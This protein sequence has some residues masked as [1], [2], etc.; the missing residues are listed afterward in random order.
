VQHLFLCAQKTLFEAAAVTD[1]Q[2]AARAAQ[3]LQ[4][5]VSVG[6]GKC[7][8]FLHEHRFSQF[9]SLLHRRRVLAFGRG[10]K[11]RGHFRTGNNFVVAR[12]K[13]I[14]ARLLGQRAR[15]LRILIRNRQEAN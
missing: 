2:I 11:Y 6:E 5:I 3:R 8:R 14:G 15:P 12:G 10:D 4:N 9:E 7:E 1:P 13:K